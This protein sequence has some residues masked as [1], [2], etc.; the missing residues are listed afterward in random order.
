MACILKYVSQTRV[1]TNI[2][3]RKARNVG[4][5]T[6]SIFSL[7]AVAIALSFLAPISRADS[8]LDDHI[9]DSLRRAITDE[10]YA[11]GMYGAFADVGD[12][13]GG[14]AHRLRMYVDPQLRGG[15]GWVIYKL[16]P[17]GEVYRR[18]VVTKDREAVLQGDLDGGFPPTQASYLTVFMDDDEL[19][20]K[21]SSWRQEFFVIDVEPD[22]QTVQSAT[23][24]YERQDSVE[25]ESQDK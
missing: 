17:I 22:R 23:K 5:K 19:C 16:M 2:S 20:A 11:N 13:A 21:K 15:S 1:T 18:F 7:A 9:V 6:S 24:R 8:S 12:P 3:Y 25:K 14:S 10:I 4:Q